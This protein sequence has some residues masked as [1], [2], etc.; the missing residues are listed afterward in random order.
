M[1]ETG[2]FDGRA[3]G[4][5][6]VDDLEMYLQ[7]LDP[8]L[9]KFKEEFSKFSVSSKATM[10]FLRPREVRTM[11]IPEVYK[12]MVISEIIHLQSPSSRTKFE[13]AADSPAQGQALTQ[14][15]PG[16]R[17]NDS[18]LSPPPACKQNLFESGTASTESTT[19]DDVSEPGDS[20]DKISFIEKEKER[21][22]E[23][24][25]CLQ[26]VLASKKTELNHLKSV[27]E[28]QAAIGIGGGKPIM[29][30]ICDRC[31][32]QGHRQSGNKGR[33]TCEFQKCPGYHYCGLLHKHPEHKQ[34]ISQVSLY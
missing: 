13:E 17:K 10:K 26:A 5:P 30:V 6:T 28:K 24:Q 23:E 18:V 2:K 7:S 14:G 9:S 31:H 3:D 25:F 4:N 21:L 8:G 34:N 19:K 12:R 20:G 29:R 11:D 22:H 16:R 32:H 15:E 27:P 33:K 1:A